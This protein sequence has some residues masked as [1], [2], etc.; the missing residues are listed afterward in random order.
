MN[1]NKVLELDPVNTKADKLLKSDNKY[2]PDNLHISEME[3]KL[4]EFKLNDN[5]KTNLYFA[6]AKA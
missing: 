3:K 1:L 2:S 6:L 5:Q 4:K